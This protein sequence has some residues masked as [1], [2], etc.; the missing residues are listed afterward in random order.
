MKLRNSNF[1]QKKERFSH[2][3][4]LILMKKR[5]VAMS[6]IWE[7]NRGLI[8]II[9][10]VA[11]FLLL[12]ELECRFVKAWCLVNVVPIFLSIVVG[13]WFGPG[14]NAFI[15]GGT[16]MSEEDV[17]EQMFM[18][19]GFIF[20]MIFS[21]M[22]VFLYFVFLAPYARANGL[23]FSFPSS[24]FILVSVVGG[25]AGCF[26]IVFFRKPTPR[27]SQ[28]SKIKQKNLHYRKDTK[29]NTGKIT[30]KARNILFVLCAIFVINMI[31][32]IVIHNYVSQLFFEKLFGIAI[33]A[34]AIPFYVCTRKLERECP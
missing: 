27:L 18:E 23:L 20:G 11:F 19:L 25:I 9:M 7:D 8:G 2:L 29:T 4:K 24:I 26:G 13:F 30:K 32:L 5:R 22:A 17:K 16:S 3:E 1:K 21:V 12:F 15:A 14:F 33:L 6:K 28:Y 31:F 34:M 10:Y